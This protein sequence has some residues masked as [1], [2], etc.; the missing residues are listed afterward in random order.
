M[1][2]IVLILLV[3]CAYCVCPE[4]VVSDTKSF[5]YQTVVSSA[6]ADTSKITPKISFATDVL[7]LRTTGAL[8][9]LGPLGAYG[10]LSSL[11]PVG[12]NFFNPS[13]LISS[14]DWSGLSEKLTNNGGPLSKDG[15]LGSNGPLAADKLL[16]LGCINDF[17]SQLVPGGLRTVLGPIG[18][19]GPL[20]ALG[21]LGPVGAHG[22]E[23]D[24]NGRYIDTKANKVVQSVMVA[25]DKN[26]VQSWD[27]Y[28]FYTQDHASNAED[29]DSSFMVEGT[30]GNGD[31]YLFKSSVEQFVTIV[32]VPLMQYDA[33]EL[34]IED[35]NGN[36]VATSNSMIYIN[37]VQIR[38]P[39]GTSLRAKVNLKFSGH[40]LPSTYRLYVTGSS[41]MIN[42][43]YV[44]GPHLVEYTPVQEA[45]LS[46]QDE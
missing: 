6:K 45:M 8:G 29:N 31:S 26:K 16:A 32:V 7:G 21:A 2:A 30:I 42:S 22:F 28:E 3:A 1:K 9:S 25:Y 17:S 18:P 14:F 37:W 10:P 38:V 15:P 20:G 24:E 43:T 27:L 12:T 34:V 41:E 44:N 33:F 5:K 23:R 11:G 40:I 46:M 35:A 36:T 39:K 4:K 19:L 13:Q